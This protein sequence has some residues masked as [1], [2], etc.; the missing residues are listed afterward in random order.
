MWL[1]TSL[2]ST[3]DYNF[4]V[5][6]YQSL[7]TKGDTASHAKQ[8]KYRAEQI[9]NRCKF[10]I[11]SDI[12]ASKVQRCLADLRN[13]ENGLSVQTSNYYLQSIKQFCRWMVQDG[14]AS[15]SP[16]VHLTRINAKG[17]QRHDR[18][19]LEP[20]EMRRLLEVTI[21]GPKRFVWKAMREPF[22]IVWLL[23]P[24]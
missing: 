14:R 10:A 6:D 22:Y 23:K 15:E 1:A 2:Y 24:A 12:S 4:K 11:W 8:P 21:A 5:T 7:L 17:D 9:I 3:K 20:D 16:V 19:A 13:E 18:R